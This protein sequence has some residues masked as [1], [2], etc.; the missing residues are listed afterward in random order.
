MQ[1]GTADEICKRKHGDMAWHT[2]WHGTV[3]LLKTYAA[4]LQLIQGRAGVQWKTSGLT[5]TIRALVSNKDHHIGRAAVS[6]CAAPGTL[7]AAAAV[8]IAPS[9]RNSLLSTRTPCLFIP[10]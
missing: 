9:F 3:V 1:F 4:P 10:L 7:L 5:Q 6:L 8:A 2:E